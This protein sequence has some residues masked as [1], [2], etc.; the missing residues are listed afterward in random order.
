MRK[1]TVFWTLV[2]A[3]CLLNACQ[4]N[5]WNDHYDLDHT[6]SATKN[7]LEI[8]EANEQFSKF[9]SI[10][11]SEGMDSVLKADQTFTVWA[12]T[13][14]AMDAYQADNN[15][16]DHFIKNHVCRYVYTVSDFADTSY[17]RINMLNGKFQEYQK[18]SNGYTFASKPIMGSDMAATNGIIHTLTEIAPFYLNLYEEILENATM[19]SVASYL[20]SYDTYEFDK[21]SSTTIG[22]NEYGQ[23]VYDSVF[24]YHNEWMRKYGSIYLEDSTYTMFVPT[25]TG[26]NRGYEKVYPY[27]R[28][29]G[30]VLTSTENATTHVPTRTYAV[31]DYLAD[32]LSRAFTKENMMKNLVFRKKVNPSNAPGDSLTNTAGNTFHNVSRLVAETE[33]QVVSNGAIWKTEDWTLRPDET[34]LKEIEV[35][36]EN[37]YGR[38][39]AYANVLSQTAASTMYADSVS[40][41][42]YIE[43]TASSTSVRSQPMIQFTIPNVLAATYDIYVVFA[44]PQ[45]N[46]SDVASDSTRVN[47]YINYVHEDGTMREDPVINGGVTKAN[48]M[49]NMFVTRIKFPYSNFSGTAFS[50]N[51]EYADDC[52]RLRIQT[53][54]AKD[55]TTKMTRTMRIDKIVLRPTTEN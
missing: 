19:D 11:K 8:L 52:V 40:G 36:A 29:F 13:N 9:L 24:N 15:V 45:A 47:F 25:N 32:S 51:Q 22:K 48:S 20:K 28:T 38:T 6:S 14:E 34:F 3:L 2:S 17:V 21:S 41:Q 16:V 55:E 23:I 43:V 37:T 27:F 4:D 44:P 49:T 50:K 12:P 18:E 33:E 53:N 30:K 1:I 54:V 5:A 42:K 7:I 35:E 26:W 10:V 31:N 46:S 39:Y